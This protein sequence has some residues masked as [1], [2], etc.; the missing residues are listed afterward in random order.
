MWKYWNRFVLCVLKH[1][2]GP[3]AS[4]DSAIF[5]L[6]NASVVKCRSFFSVVN[7]WGFPR[8]LTTKGILIFYM[9]F[10]AKPNVSTIVLKTGSDRP[11]E[12]VRPWTGGYSGPSPISD[13]I[14]NWT[15]ANRLNSLKT[16]DSTDFRSQTGLILF[17][18]FIRIIRTD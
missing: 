2:T 5:G 18:I 11:V 10:S 15:G 6:Q 9:C 3:E 7:C 13:R 16:G 12:P 4:V 8:Q 17:S 1:I 14:C